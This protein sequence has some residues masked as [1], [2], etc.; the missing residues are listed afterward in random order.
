MY[1][2]KVDL[3]MLDKVDLKTL[4][5][6]DFKTLDKADLLMLD[7]AE[8][9]I[10]ARVDQTKGQEVKVDPMVKIDLKM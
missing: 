1:K 3:K 2:V 8:L 5:K 4:D 7:K 9:K 10:Q 6:A